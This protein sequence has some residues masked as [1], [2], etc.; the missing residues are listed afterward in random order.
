MFGFGFTL[1]FLITGQWGLPL[2]KFWRISFFA[3][4]IISCGLTYGLGVYDKKN[5]EGE[6]VTVGWKD[7][8]LI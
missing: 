5:W 4:F 3:L 6:T 7:M 8:L 1:V 2:N